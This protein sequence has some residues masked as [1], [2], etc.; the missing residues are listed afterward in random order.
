MRREILTTK[1][2]IAAL[3]VTQMVS[4]QQVLFP[5]ER[6]RRPFLLTTAGLRLRQE[7]DSR[8]TGG[9]TQPASMAKEEITTRERGNEAR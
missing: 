9:G 8:Q 4:D 1:E 2:L 5:A 7:G 6:C 3:M